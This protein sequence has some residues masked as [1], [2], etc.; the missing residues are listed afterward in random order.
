M[1]RG[2]GGVH[3]R[4]QPDLRA[5]AVGD[6]EFVLLVDS[7]QLHR[8]QPDVPALVFGVEFLTALQ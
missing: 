1:G 2:V 7:G 5:I 8:R 6:D 3:Q 4:Q